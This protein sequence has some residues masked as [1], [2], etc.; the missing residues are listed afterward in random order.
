M[1]PVVEFVSSSQDGHENESNKERL[2][3]VDLM[4]INMS[5]P[6]ESFL[7]AALSLKDQV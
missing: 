3:L 4:T 6:R 7:K 2:D 5:L 1:S